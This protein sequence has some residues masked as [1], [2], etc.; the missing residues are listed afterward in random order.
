[1]KTTRPFLT[2]RKK[3]VGSALLVIL[4][5]LVVVTIVGMMAI[6]GGINELRIAR[7]DRLAKRNF[8]NA[9]AALNDALASFE[10]IYANTPDA[11]GNTLYP[12]PD[13]SLPIR[14]RDIE[15]SGVSFASPL[16]EDGIPLAWIE[17]RAVLLKSNKK[18]S[19]LSSA[20]ESIPSMTHIGPAPEGFDPQL[21]NARRFAITA[22][23]IAPEGYSASNPQQSL[24]GVAIQAGLQIAEKKEK[25]RHLIG[26]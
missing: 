6:A 4:M 15:D 21:Y 9:E 17:V 3:E 12:S 10:R 25:V 1:M 24:T 14:D 13:G 23:A 2:P 16:K 20:A 8:Y 5:L 7:F 19:G 18:S 26:L 11:D 22:T